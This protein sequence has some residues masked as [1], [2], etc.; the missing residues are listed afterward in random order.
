[1]VFRIRTARSL[2]QRIAEPVKAKFPDDL[3]VIIVARNLVKLYYPFPE[4]FMSAVPIGARFLIGNFE[5]EDNTEEI[6]KK[7]KGIVKQEVR[8]VNLEWPKITVGGKAIGQATEALMHLAKT[9]YVL[10]LQACEVLTED[11]VASIK[12]GSGPMEFNFIHFFGN[13]YSKL[14]RG[15]KVAPR[16]FSGRSTM[17]AGDGCM[18]DDWKQDKFPNG[19]VIHRY[20]YCFENEAKAKAHHHYQLYTTVHGELPKDKLNEVEKCGMTRNYCE[21]HPNVVAH[22]TEW[23]NYNL[24]LALQYCLLSSTR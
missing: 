16:I 23:R 13:C 18:I 9:S 2:N 8:I 14:E 5:S 4:S 15:Y 21:P 17:K 19:G 12:M 10:N 7:L 1:M 6:Y 11:A 24:S 3:T 22:M 20:S